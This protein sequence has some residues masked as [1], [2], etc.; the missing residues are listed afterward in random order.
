[1]FRYILPGCTLAIPYARVYL[2]RGL[3]KI[4]DTYD[5]VTAGAFVDEI[6]QI[7]VGTTRFVSHCLMCALI[8]RVAAAKALTLCNVDPVNGKTKSTLVASH[9]K[10]VAEVTLALKPFALPFRI[11]PLLLTLV[12]SCQ[13]IGRAA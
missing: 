3:L 4:V 1:M 13:R 6:S 7:I 2:R 5:R 10:I 9:P 8:A 11:H 12:S